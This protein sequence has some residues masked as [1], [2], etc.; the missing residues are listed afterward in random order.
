MNIFNNNYKYINSIDFFF[1]FL[2]LLPFFPF[3]IIFIFYSNKH[4][5][6]KQCKI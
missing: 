4:N 5:N 3:I 2:L 6:I 1:F